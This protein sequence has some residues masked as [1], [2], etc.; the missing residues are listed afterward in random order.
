MTEKRYSATAV[1]A[2]R[3]IVKAEK[4]LKIETEDRIVRIANSTPAT[5][6][7]RTR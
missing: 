1:R 5:P 7:P 6:L 3:A 2:A 4:Q